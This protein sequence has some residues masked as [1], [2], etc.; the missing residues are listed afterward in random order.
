MQGDI[1]NAYLNKK[2]GP[3]QYEVLRKATLS[4]MKMKLAAI[5]TIRNRRLKADVNLEWVLDV[6]HQK[7]HKFS[8][9]DCLFCRNTLITTMIGSLP[10]GGDYSDRVVFA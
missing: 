1:T 10:F 3:G 2:M 8:Q 7:G 9:I 5:L 6:L 4:Y